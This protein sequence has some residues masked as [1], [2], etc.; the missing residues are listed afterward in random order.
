MDMI[1]R[2]K[3]NRAYL[4]SKKAPFKNGH[5]PHNHSGNDVHVPDDPGIRLKENNTNDQKR[6]NTPAEAIKNGSDYI[7]VGRP[8]TEN[9]NPF[10]VITKINAQI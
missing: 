8:I 5:M 9:N 1:Q 6:I 4:V 10:E 3:Q 7:V 2:M